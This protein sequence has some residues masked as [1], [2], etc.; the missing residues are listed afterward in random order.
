MKNTD[1]SVIARQHTKCGRSDTKKQS[2]PLQGL[3]RSY[4]RNSKYSSMGLRGDEPK[5]GRSNPLFVIPAKAGIQNRWIPACAGMTLRVRLLQQRLDCRFAMTVPL[6]LR[7]SLK[8]CLA[9]TR[10]VVSATF[11]R[12]FCHENEAI[13]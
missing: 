6:V 5:Q 12:L 9:M 13:Q 1:R 8:R 3:S 11:D 10:R 4:G 7:L 2:L